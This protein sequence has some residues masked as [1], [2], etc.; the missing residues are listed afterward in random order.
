MN[1]RYG[2]QSGDLFLQMVAERM[3]HQ[4]RPGDMLARLGG[5]EF[6]VL[7]SVLRS[8]NEAEDIA[9]RLDGCFSEPFTIRNHVVTGSASIGIA[10]Y[11]IDGATEDAL[12]SNADSAMYGSKRMRPRAGERRRSKAPESLIGQ[13]LD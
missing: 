6:G 11:P 10:V 8:R 4:L 12:M 1:D 9:R 3:K 2:H 13:S 5:D 7:V